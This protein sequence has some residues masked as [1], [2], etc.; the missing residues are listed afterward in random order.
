MLPQLSVLPNG[1]LEKLKLGMLLLPFC[2]KYLQ[3]SSAG[4][5]SSCLLR[6]DYTQVY[7]RLLDYQKKGRKCALEIEMVIVDAGY[8][9]P[10]RLNTKTSLKKKRK[11]PYV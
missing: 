9:N 2:R 7:S 10:M 1:K 6:F 4:L 3:L 11:K 5:I 8:G